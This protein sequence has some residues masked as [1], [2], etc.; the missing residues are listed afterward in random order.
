LPKS[1]CEKVAEN[2][3]YRQYMAFYVQVG[4]METVKS[5]IEIVF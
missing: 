2:W 3:R 1:F 5:G 4:E